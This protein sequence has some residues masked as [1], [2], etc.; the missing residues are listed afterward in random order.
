MSAST[1]PE[2]YHELWPGPPWHSCTAPIAS[3]SAFDPEGDGGHE[4]DG[5]AGMMHGVRRPA[6]H[7]VQDLLGEGAEMLVAEQ[8]RGV[9]GHASGVGEMT[10]AIARRRPEHVRERSRIVPQRIW[11]DAEP[12]GHPQRLEQH[13]PLRVG[14]MHEH[15]DVAHRLP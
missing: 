6:R 14:R 13:E 11:I 15:V 5:V 9:H 2:P 10:V 4:P 1:W 12:F 3:V 8:G 7:A